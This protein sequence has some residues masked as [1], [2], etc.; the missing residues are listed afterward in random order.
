M[1]PSQLLS[2]P[3]LAGPMLIVTASMFLNFA[4]FTIIIPVMPFL[5]GQY[6]DPDL[7][8]PLVGIITSVYAFG[9]L[10]SAPALGALSDH[11]GRR[12]V[13]LLSLTGSVIGYIVLGIG[14]ALW[15]LFLGRIIDGLTGGNISTIYA[16][17][18]DISEPRDRGRYYGI[19]GAAGGLGFI[20]GPAIGG[21]VGEFSVT[22]PMFVAAAVT[23]AN[24]VWAYFALPES[25]PADRRGGSF[26]W[27]QL[28]PLSPLTLLS[29][30]AALRIAFAAAFLFYFAATMLQSNVSVFLK[31]ILAFGPAQIG[32]VLF[33]VG[34]MDIVSQGFLTGHLL[35]RFGERALARG[36][37]FINAFGYILIALVAL[38]PSVVL[39]F[40]GVIVLTLGDGLFQPSMG[41][42]IA[43]AAPRGAQG[44]VQGANQAQQSIARIVG[45]LLAAYLYTVAPSAPYVV[46]AC[47]VLLGLTILSVFVHTP[48]RAST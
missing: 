3:R 48:V 45:P 5:I 40:A 44:A 21:F 31:D 36:G 14:G 27:S 39:I 47:V 34:V 12:P 22:A 33:V 6:V 11:V 32:I 23:T 20:V 19:L 10:I 25:V 37:L 17:V 13:L 26:T 16:Y 42:I 18:A 41:G 2:L 1:F 7:V 9:Q 24:I 29:K 4:G 46:A 38:V 30:S 8:G 35:P 43:N 15:V 28:N